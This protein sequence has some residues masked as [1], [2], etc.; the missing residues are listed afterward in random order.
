[1][2]NVGLVLEGGGM[3]G[4]YTAGVLDFFHDIKLPF[5]TVV[6]ASAGAGNG[7]S[8]VAKQRGRNYQVIVDYG[9][10]PEYISFK[11]LI[12]SKELFGMDFIFNTLPKK[13]VPF[14]FTTFSLNPIEFVVAATDVHTGQPV[15]YDFF[16]TQE[17]LLQ[18]IR[19]SSSLPLLAPITEYKG[20]H[21]MDGGIADPIPLTPSIQAGNKK[22]I[23]VLTRNK[24]YIKKPMKFI[25]YINRKLKDYPHFVE[26]LKKRH[27]K[28][29]E[30]MKQ[31]EEMEANNQAIIIRP[32][33]P[34]D[35][36]RIE[37][38]KDKLQEL[39]TQGY[40]D[41]QKLKSQLLEFVK[42]TSRISVK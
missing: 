8:F 7:S 19:A 28:Y 39:Y 29:N 31:L 21:L 10:H 40:N 24:G 37:N 25:W 12:R 22:H 33:K 15:Y 34:L 32:I 3:R 1:M 14:D 4:A 16:E 23:V 38:N 42:P 9:D 36:S 27:I 17:D 41:A 26:A 5:S 11:R 35:V 6:G 18:V 30:T 13:L 2:E 20:K